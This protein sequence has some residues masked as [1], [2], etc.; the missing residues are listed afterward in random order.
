ME[1]VGENLSSSQ[2]DVEEDD[3][4]PKRGRVINE[5]NTK[6]PFSVNN[7]KDIEAVPLDLH[8]QVNRTKEIPPEKRVLYK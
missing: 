2:E 8:G 4:M 6:L 5:L 7:Q 3:D 1:E